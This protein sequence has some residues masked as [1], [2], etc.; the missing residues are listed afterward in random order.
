MVA[1]GASPMPQDTAHQHRYVNQSADKYE[2][3]Y[4]L[5]T[6]LAGLLGVVTPGVPVAGLAAA[7]ILWQIKRKESPFIDDHGRDA[8]NFQ[9]SLA[10]YTVAAVALSVAL[11]VVSFGLLAPI[12][13]LLAPV[14]AVLLLA[15]TLI[16][17]IRGAL[18]AHRGE[19]YRYPVCIRLIPDND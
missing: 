12:F 9:I 17:C 16:G 15:V 2:R 7:V 10:L 6:H 19:Y 3:S 4:A 13:V 14:G 1:I 5:W 18:A 11:S 8:V